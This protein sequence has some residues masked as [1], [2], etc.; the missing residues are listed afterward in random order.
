HLVGDFIPKRGPMHGLYLVAPALTRVSPCVGCFPIRG[1]MQFVPL[2]ISAYGDQ[3]GANRSLA[4][5]LGL[6]LKALQALDRLALD[7]G[8]G[9]VSS[10]DRSAENARRAAVAKHRWNW[11]TPAFGT[12][13]RVLAPVY[14]EPSSD[15]PVRIGRPL[16][17]KRRQPFQSTSSLMILNTITFSPF[18]NETPS[19]T[20]SSRRSPLTCKA[21]CT[22]RPFT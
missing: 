19:M 1:R 5:G 15:A 4:T 18:R 13:R 7:D 20:S 3:S 9:C 8:R 12:A 11:R 22:A 6:S 10:S 17:R 16:S 2:S 21:L 14:R